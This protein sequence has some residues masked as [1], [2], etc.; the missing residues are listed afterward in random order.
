[1]EFE[2]LD[3]GQLL[4]VS[5]D[6][7][8]PRLRKAHH[9]PSFPIDW[10]VANL[11]LKPLDASIDTSPCCRSYTVPTRCI[12]NSISYLNQLVDPFFANYHAQKKYL[13]RT[14]TT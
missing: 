1:L 4:P 8:G 9:Q 12:I 14:K 2:F 7:R 10:V 13:R 5:D 11:S 3:A 6:F